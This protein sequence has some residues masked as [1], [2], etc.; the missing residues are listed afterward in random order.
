MEFAVDGV[1]SPCREARPARRLVRPRTPEEP[2][3]RARDA[4]AEGGHRK[5]TRPL[6]PALGL[7]PRYCTVG[8][9]S[10][11]ATGGA[12]P[13]M[14]GRGSASPLCRGR[15]AG[16]GR[17]LGSGG[18]GAHRRGRGIGGAGVGEGRSRQARRKRRRTPTT[19]R[20]L[21]CTSTRNGGGSS[22]PGRRRTTTALEDAGYSSSSPGFSGSSRPPQA[23]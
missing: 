6:P 21:R 5:D 11:A 13:W 23:P 3:A 17:S 9:C 22:A 8:G 12:S 1:R 19:R 4:P 15:R 7:L 14:I 2:R 18:V 20:G 16:L 10:G